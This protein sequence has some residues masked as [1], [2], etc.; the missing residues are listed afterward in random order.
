VPLSNI[1]VN[2]EAKLVIE[3]ATKKPAVAVIEPTPKIESTTNQSSP[4]VV[5]TS[6]AAPTP[7]KPSA[8]PKQNNDNTAGPKQNL[9]AVLQ[10]KYGKEYDIEEVKES[11]SLTMEVLKPC[12]DEYAIFLEANAKHASAGT[13][14]LAQLNI[15]DDTHFT[16]T[17]GALT[18]QKFV[19]QE[20]MNVLEKVWEK[21]QNRAIQFDI[22]VEASEQEDVPLHMRLNSKQKYDRIADQYPLVKELK[23]R[24][25]LEVYF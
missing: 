2:T 13:F 8:I 19:E 23:N 12:W 20:R 14:K 16:V 22:L 18:A 5:T 7:A 6:T 25:N 4:A 24:C 11:I 1:A 10:Q 9:L 21:F 17:V 3:I 15:I